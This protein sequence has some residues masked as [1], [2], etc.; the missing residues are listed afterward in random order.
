MKKEI[1]A[2]NKMN[3]PDL[4]FALELEDAELDARVEA[5]SAKLANRIS[6]LESAFKK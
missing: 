4:L 1:Q 5:T 3:L 2:L 6:R